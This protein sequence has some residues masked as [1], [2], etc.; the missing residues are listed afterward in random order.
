MV[1]TTRHS[2]GVLLFREIG[3]A[4]EVFLVHLGGPFWARKDRGAWSI[5]KGEFSND[6]DPLHAAL[7]EFQEETGHA[8]T[9][10]EIIPLRPRRLKSG[11]VVHAWAARGD[12]DP[13]RLESN[14]FSMEWPPRSGRQQDFPEV[15]RAEWFPLHIA[16]D[17]IS[18][19]Q[20]GFLNELESRLT[21]GRP[22][23][24]GQPTD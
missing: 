1:T 17:K 12:V 20:A 7:R 18:N 11:K 14:T 19:G 13:A 22:D 16:R 4:V 9:A 21:R 5:P 15:D 6:E 2:A 8:V 3:G 10:D 24:A 23:A